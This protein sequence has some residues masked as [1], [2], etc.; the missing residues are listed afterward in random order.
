M[1]DGSDGFDFPLGN[2]D[3]GGRM[4]AT[5]ANDGDGFYVAGDFGDYEDP[6]DSAM[7]HAT[8]RSPVGRRAPDV[9]HARMRGEPIVTHSKLASPNSSDLGATIP[10]FWDASGRNSWCHLVH[11]HKRKIHAVSRNILI[12]RLILVSGMLVTNESVH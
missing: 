8:I 9:T 4:T 11:R 10:F 6:S 5:E 2:V 1:P 3:I 7:D 12:W